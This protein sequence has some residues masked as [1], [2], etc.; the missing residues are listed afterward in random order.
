M[1]ITNPIPAYHYIREGF[2]AWLASG[3]EREWTQYAARKAGLKMEG[4][5]II[6]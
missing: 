6:V 3:N 4:N 5:R 1:T 2:A